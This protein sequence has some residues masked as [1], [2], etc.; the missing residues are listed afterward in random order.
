MPPVKL[1]VLLALSVI[2]LVLPALG[3]D[4]SGQVS[5]SIYVDDDFGKALV[6]GYIDD[7]DRLPFLNASGQ[8]YE[9]DT[10]MVYAVTGSLIDKDGS[11]W[12]LKFPL[13]G[14]YDEYHA[15]FYIPGKVDL[16]EVDCSNGLDFLSSSYN[17]SLV[18]D[19]HGFDLKDPAVSI[20]YRA[21]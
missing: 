18:L 2:I 8:I 5:L 6:V 17:G 15:V 12:Y 11:D 10:G 3:A 16:R 7:Y 14:S 9:K 13:K 19:V 1:V 4:G 21:A 20:S